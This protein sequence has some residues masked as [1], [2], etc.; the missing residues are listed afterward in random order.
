[1][2]AVLVVAAVGCQADKPVS[3]APPSTS[4]PTSTVPP[5]LTPVRP[6]LEPPPR[7][8][9][10]TRNPLTGRLGVP[11]GP[12][13]AVKI[14]NTGPARPQVGLESAD[15]VYVEQVE[16]GQTRLVAVFA[17]RRPRRVEPVRSVRNAD[18]ELL[19]GYGR[20]ALAYS[21]GAGGPLAT[22]HRSPLIDAS[23][24]AKGF[25]YHR[26]GSRH[27]PYNLA[28]DL[29]RLAA[30][31]PRATARVRDVGFRWDGR[32]D[33][34]LARARQVTRLTAVIGTTAVSF[35]WDWRGHRWV[36]TA[37]DGSV[38][39]SASGTPL[40][41][42]NV[43]LQFCPVTVDRTD[44]DVR[45]A[46]SAYTHT[47]GTGRA[48]VFRDGRG[49]VGRWVRPTRGAPTR[50]VD[51]AGRDLALKPGGVW[52]LLVPAGGRWAAR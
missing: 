19:A 38:R 33:S 44:V 28:V 22:L 45:G 7:P 37:P 4:A 39:R 10:M 25:A 9:R 30:R 18:P 49:V 48:V 42:P 43:I 8:P 6:H 1:V 51:A 17:S 12:V 47:I 34:R 15:V 40:G 2:L 21:G 20:V 23:P 50:F 52:V 24:A 46:P 35:R 29:P 36:Q 32:A 5:T 16:G 3:Q 13:I 41:A 31:L 11:S 14:D 26:D 27:A